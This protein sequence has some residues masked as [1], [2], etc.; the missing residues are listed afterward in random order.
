MRSATAS[1]STRRWPTFNNTGVGKSFR[2]KA[3]K[4]RTLRYRL[5]STIDCPVKAPD[6]AN[7]ERI[8]PACS[9]MREK[10]S[11]LMSHVSTTRHGVPFCNE[12][13][14]GQYESRTGA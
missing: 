5:V 13:Y 3:K 10:S 14:H 2:T 8:A 12:T 7:H 9:I 1:P 4:K 11:R 6:Q